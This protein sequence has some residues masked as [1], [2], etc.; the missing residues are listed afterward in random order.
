MSLPPSGPDAIPEETARLARTINPKGTVYMHIRDHLGTI[1]E[2]QVF[3]PF[4][5]TK[6]QPA[7]APWRLVLVCIFQFIEG[8]TDRQAAEA[9]QQ[10]IDWKYA[11][12]LE[13][14]DPGFDFSVLC[15]FRARL[16]AGGKEMEL[17]DRLLAHLKTLGLLKARGHQRTDSTHVLA[18]V[19]SLNRLE[20]V[21]ET[22]RHALNILAEVAPGWLQTHAAPEWY[23]RYGRR[24]ENY[25][26]PKAETERSEL[27]ATI[28]DDGVQLLR[29]VETAEGLPWLQELPAIQTLRQVW[30]EQYTELSGGKSCFR[31]KKDL[32]SPADL[33]VSPYDTDA[34]FS[35]KRGMEWIGYK[36]HFTETCDEEMPHLITHVE[37][38]TAAVPDDQV[39]ET[40]HQALAR[41]EVLPDVHLVDAGYT[42]AEGLV[43]SQRD[44]GVPLLGPVAADPSWQAKA[45][46]GFD[47]A[48]FLI[49]WEREVAICPV[50][51]QNYSWLPNGDRSRGVVGGIRVQFSGRDCSPCPLRSQCTRAKTAPRELVLLPRD[52]Y[53]A[54][55][56]AK[57]RQSTAEFREEYALRA[58]IESTHAQGIRRSD[59]RR[60]R[61]I[62]LAKTRLQHMFTAIALNL[63]RAVEWL[64]DTPQ[65]QPPQPKTRLSRFATLEKAIA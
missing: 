40:V 54:L 13:L 4:F 37:T 56:A 44:Y 58:G 48:S 31:E 53:E 52:R 3:A 23:E 45:A 49:D 50:G 19:R 18:A 22:M 60:S 34:R 16:I 29:A 2:N 1:Y 9:V 11:L 12:S 36:V 30:A 24:M 15:K 39:L 61:Y 28:G 55:R 25:R 42:D 51:K 35:V 64:T 46:E 33:I 32:E 38:T 20:R 7:E 27:G 57:S 63:V 43:S 47:K 41:H 21:G 17:F 5:S 65:T 10:R 62:G 14:S 6:G 59:L 26:F 8:L